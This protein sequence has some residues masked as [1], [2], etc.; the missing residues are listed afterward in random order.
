MDM[1]ISNCVHIKREGIHQ[2]H[3]GRSRRN[4]YK[5]EDNGKPVYGESNKI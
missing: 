1:C 2:G 4:A 5:P 3:E